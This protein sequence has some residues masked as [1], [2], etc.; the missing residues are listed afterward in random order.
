[1]FPQKLAPASSPGRTQ[2]VELGWKRVSGPVLPLI[3]IL[4][5]AGLILLPGLLP[6]AEQTPAPSVASEQGRP[7]IQYYGPKDYHALPYCSTAV[8]DQAGLLYVGNR[9]CVLCFDGHA[10]TSIPTG[11]Q[12]INALELDGTDRIWIGG[13]SELGCL[14]SDGRGGRTFQSLKDQ[15]PEAE[16]NFGRIYHVYALSHGIYFVGADRIL[17]WHGN[18]FTV[19]KFGHRLL[20]SRLADE[21]YVHVFGDVL[22]S[23]D[24]KNWRI[25]ADQP[26]VRVESDAV[27]GVAPHPEGGL[28]LCMITGS[29][30]RLNQGRLEATATDFDP[31]RKAAGRVLNFYRLA[32]GTLALTTLKGTSLLDPAGRLRLHLDEENG[33][34]PSAANS[35]HLDRSGHVWLGLFS[36][37]ARLDWP[38]AVT[39]L[40]MANGSASGSVN[41]LLRHRGRLYAGTNMGLLRLE[42]AHDSGGKL[43]SARLV[44][45]PGC[46]KRVSKLLSAGDDLLVIAW[47]G[48][49]VLGGDATELVSVPSLAS[50]Y[51]ICGLLPDGRKDLA[52]V[53]TGQSLVRLVKTEGHWRESGTIPGFQ[54]RLA[55]LID[56]RDGS[57]WGITSGLG[58][59]RFVGLTGVGKGPVQVEH[60]TEW[61]GAGGGKIDHEPSVQEQDGRV[62]FMDVK[63][64][65]RFD[66]IT[67]QFVTD[68]SATAEL[69][70]LQAGGD[71]YPN[72]YPSSQPGVRWR[73][74]YADDPA[75]LPFGGRKIWRNDRAGRRDYLAYGAVNALDPSLELLEESDGE[76]GSVLWLFGG[77]ALLRAKLPAALA[78]P[79]EFQTRLRRIEDDRHGLQPLQAATPLR[80]PAGTA[81]HLAAATDLL[82]GRLVAYRTRL[83]ELPWSGWSDEHLFHLERLGPGTHSFTIQAK[84]AEGNLA[85]P[86]RYDFIIIPPWWQNWWALGFYGLAA[87]GSVLGFARWRTLRL[88][89]LTREL[90]HKVEE[91][92]L[93]LT[94]KTEQLSAAKA[95]ADAANASKS[96][97][98][99]SM[100]HEIRNPMNGILGIT[101]ILTADELS[102]RHRAL[103]NTLAACTEQLRSTMDDV[104]DFR[105]LEKGEITLTEGD[106]EL[107]ELVRGACAAADLNGDRILVREAFSAPLRLHG[108]PGKLR[109]ILGNYLSNA[110][111]YGIP[112]RAEVEVETAPAVSGRTMVTVRVRNQGPVLEKEELDSLFTLFYR[113]SRARESGVSGTGLGLAVCRRLAEAM[114]GATGVDS[115]PNGWTT[116]WITLPL[117]LAGAETVAPLA[118]LPRGGRI[119]VVEDEDYNRLVLGHLLVKLG[120]EADWAE[121]GGVALSLAAQQVYRGVITDWMLPDMSGGELIRRLREIR[122]ERLPPVLVISAY[123]TTEKKAEALGAGATAFLTKPIDERKLQSA[124]TALFQGRA[125]PV[126]PLLLPGEEV[127]LYFDFSPLL[128]LGDKPRVL[129]QFVHDLE[130]EW[131]EI[132][133][134]AAATAAEAAD[135][136]HRLHSQL[137]LVQ[138]TAA[139]DQLRLLET[140]LREGWTAPECEKLIACTDREIR[141]VAAAARKASVS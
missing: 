49:W 81:L 102:P 127:P 54:D 16:R 131:A 110:L 48:V 2:P 136:A 25:V 30:F 77:T 68:E 55:N 121:R 76:A 117:T 3:S 73:L 98:I 63:L 47:G 52:Y 21:I 129:E 71:L 56:A 36:G 24:G 88:E 106:F 79:R 7:L 51:Y 41:C 57:V 124:L 45:V 46:D 97:F 84:D 50:T 64:A 90:E 35:V 99:A 59:Y 104:L 6:A 72:I 85:S 78:R 20:S 103:L 132:G 137:L 114:G 96:E 107:G 69:A 141:G 139:A 13:N 31:L 93:A 40:P 42:P 120:F 1:M 65:R 115:Q 122:G 94:V 17:R 28:L 105:S 8:Q 83:G 91:R 135:R 112:A 67:H 32:D 108:D 19:E 44:P 34:L 140:A 33:G 66:P 128:A 101:R 27:L 92:T 133:R 22:R 138:A 134:P 5:L 89:R 82:E 126:E 113:G 60:Y 70:H 111:K 38:V 100:N 18:K 86:A 11:G 116:F 125:A 9:D 10:W 80:F 74:P 130:Q 118:E 12:V 119:L 14:E 4:L 87:L 39:A 26:E 123:A 75:L 15:L 43:V 37:I 58:I 109:Q 29:F 95:E 61:T 53:G 62:L 23:F